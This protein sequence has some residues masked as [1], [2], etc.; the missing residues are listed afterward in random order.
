MGC[1]YAAE[2]RSDFNQ[3]TR[4]FLGLRHAPLDRKKL[5]D[6]NGAMGRKMLGTW[7]QETAY[8]VRGVIDPESRRIDGHLHH[9]KSSA[10]GTVCPRRDR[11]DDP[12]RKNGAG[13]LVLRRRWSRRLGTI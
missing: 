5:L 7:Q 2:V 9:K 3:Q 8:D 13:R 1:S 4:L 12:N 11:Q 10:T 6:R